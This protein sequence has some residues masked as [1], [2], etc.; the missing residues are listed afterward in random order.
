MV[1]Q[2]LVGAK[3]LKMTLK[4]EQKMLD[5]IAFN[6]DLNQWPNHRCSEITIAYRLDVNE[7]RGIRNVQL[8]IEHLE[9]V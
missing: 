1:E 4:H 5:A 7:Y 6:I 2:R 3:H 9:P 8:M